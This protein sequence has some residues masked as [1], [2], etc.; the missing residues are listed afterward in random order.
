MSRGHDARGARRQGSAATRFGTGIRVA[1]FVVGA[2]V[3]AAVPAAAYLTVG[4]TTTGSYS[5]AIA[6]SLNGG[7]TPTLGAMS[8]R[9]VTL[10]WTQSTINHKGAAATGYTIN[11]YSTSSG[12]TAIPATGGC[13]G[14]IAALTCTE[15]N[16]APGSWWYTVTPTYHSWTGTESGRLAVTVSAP[17]F[18]ITSG[19]TVVAANGGPISTGT[20]TNFGDNETLVFHLDSAAGTTLTTS[21]ISVTANG[22][23]SANVTSFTIPAGISAGTHTIVAIGGTSGL[24][25]TSNGFTATQA[26]SI[27]SANSTTFFAGTAGSFTVT[28][29]GVPTPTLTNAA[30][31]GCTPSTLPTG[32]TF[33]DNGNGT[34]TVASTTGSPVTASVTF[35]INASNGVGTNATQTFTL[36]IDTGKLAIT[37]A[38]VS[39]ATSSTPN[40]GQITVQRQTGSGTPITTG[41][42]L[43]VNLS[44]SPSTGATF[45]TAQFGS[46]VTS[47]TIASGA[48]S[49]TFWYGLTSTGTPSITTSATSYVSGSQQETITTAP[50]GL[51][52]AL[53]SSGSTGTPVINCG[54]P[55]TSYTCNVTGVG[56]GGHV[57]F[58]ATFVNS[59]GTQVVYSA[60]Q[61]STI[62]ETGQNTGSVTIGA[63]ASSS[64]P[65]SLT[66]S[67][68]GSS[69]KTSTLTFGP[70]TLTI[71]VNS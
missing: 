66:A 30:F 58:Y 6:D 32:V 64:S 29:S 7:N 52:M 12:G 51:G 50:A 9:N 20:L 11:R 47:V 65:N 35:C 28:T 24:S 37:S 21:P 59:S 43:T 45:G 53:A 18:S 41:G 40:L 23:G 71:N 5:A 62:T 44:S 38:A 42:A 1:L 68:T 57:A 33:T 60:T 49:A 31:A 67:H 3:A 48:S 17:T 16:V 70:Y 55:G 13:A 14:T 19:Q 46:T 15:Q 26:P 10:S 34:A 56:S 27:T 63:N 69:T 22:S 36:S 2:L 39:G 8:G 25:A 61:A 54:T 4:V